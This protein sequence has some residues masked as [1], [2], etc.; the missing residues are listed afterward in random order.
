VADHPM[1]AREA[2][3]LGYLYRRAELDRVIAP[4]GTNVDQRLDAILADLAAAGVPPRPLNVL[5]RATDL[6]VVGAEADALA[7]LLE[8]RQGEPTA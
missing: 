2:A 4:T 5:A 3:R 6:G 1:D 8:H 7:D